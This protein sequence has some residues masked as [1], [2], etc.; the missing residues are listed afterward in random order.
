M[1]GEEEEEDAEDDVEVRHGDGEFV[2]EDVGDLEAQGAGGQ[3]AWCWIWLLIFGEARKA[4]TY[5]R[6]ITEANPT[7]VSTLPN[8]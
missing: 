4:R 6:V 3:L 5:M 8:T 1:E 7:L 2:H